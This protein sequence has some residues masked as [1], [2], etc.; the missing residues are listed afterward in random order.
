[1]KRTFTLR[2][3]LGVG[4]VGI[5]LVLAIPMTLA[6]RSMERLHRITM[7]LRNGEFAA[8]LL[9]GRFHDGVDNLRRADDALLFVHDSTSASRMASELASMRTMSDSLDVYALREPATMVRLALDSLNVL[10]REEYTKAKQGRSADAEVI[11]SQWVRP[12][13]GVL[14]QTL[15]A[16]EQQLR[17]RTSE[18]VDAATEATARAEKV[19]VA[20]LL[21]SLIL[22]AL[23]AIWL[24]HSIS[25]PVHDLEVGMHAVAG[26][27]LS[28]RLA[29]PPNR[30]NEFGRLSASYESMVQ[31][32]AELD[33]LKAEFISVASHE[34]KTPINVILGYIELLEEGIYGKISDSQ[35]EV[36]RTIAGQADNLTRLVRRLLDVSRFEA[37]GGKLECRQ[38]KLR[39][40]LDTLESSFN[41]LAMQRE[42][43]LRI[44]LTED[45]PEE[46]RW[47]EDRM[48]E[49][50]GNLLS[51]AFKFTPRGGRVELAAARQ[52]DQIVVR[53]SDTGAGIP[54]EQLPHIF[55]KFFQADNQ[56][57]AAVKGTGLGLAI[58]KEIVGA[59]QGTINVE[60]QI[61]HG[62]TFTITM[63]AKTDVRRTGQHVAVAAAVGEAV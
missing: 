18:R 46:V 2:G 63:P 26:G 10:T 3:R 5:A 6:V 58:A 32:L 30:Q 44:T 54:A 33:K 43:D 24:I 16:A 20:S 11:S 17:V 56:S 36:C 38:F 31:R 15:G 1:V 62:T 34:L 60:S 53:V 8:S 51:N 19:A 52:G 23:I 25:G 42:V 41:V 45:L 7:E 48:N 14:E 4:A 55:Q 39:R 22:A 40:L 27:H 35:R 61:G 13:I 37:G 28:Y 59:H 9:L 57:K 21:V 47:D 12:R 50:F 49:V 29:I